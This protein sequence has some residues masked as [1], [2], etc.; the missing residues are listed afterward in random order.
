MYLEPVFSSDDIISQ[1]PTE[2]KLFKEVNKAWFNMMNRIVEDPSALT[3][4]DI[5][6]LGTIL[7]KANERLEKVQKGLND[8]LESKRTL[9]PRFYFLS[10]EELLEILS[11]TKEPLKVQPHLK[12]CFEGIASLDFD[13]EK[14]IH[15]MYSIEGELVQFV[16]VI[17]PIASKGKVE[18]WLV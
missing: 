11:E 5:E 15:G 1:M 16:R 4:I 8:Y 17:D 3:V 7:K 18:D 2:G 10:N 14:K 6:D 13:D 9:F 12:K